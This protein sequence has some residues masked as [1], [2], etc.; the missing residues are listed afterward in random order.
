MKEIKTY[1]SHD[2]RSLEK[3][4]KRDILGYDKFWGPTQT[5]SG[6]EVGHDVG[7]RVKTDHL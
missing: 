5:E 2:Q 3:V 7:Q 6:I 1:I 4:R